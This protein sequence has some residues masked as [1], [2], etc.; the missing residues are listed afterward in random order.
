MMYRYWNA[1]LCDSDKGMGF[2]G[3]HESGQ[4]SV[5]QGQYECLNYSFGGSIV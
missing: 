2:H 1:A 5:P 3:D 4:S